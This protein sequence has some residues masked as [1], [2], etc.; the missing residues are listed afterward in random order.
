[1]E[2]NDELFRT[3]ANLPPSELAAFMAVAE[4]GGFRSAARAS[5]ASASA[6]SHAVAG[7]EAR[8]KAQLF[9][10]TTRRVALTEAGERFA[11]ALRPALKQ[12]SRA[13][14]A[15]DG[16]SDQPRGTIRINASARAAEL[17]LEPL[18]L[19]FLR[20]YPDMT[21]DIR[22]DD[23]LL[24]LGSGAFD[25]GLRLI[26]MV[27][28][29]MVAIPVGGEQQ[30]VVVAAPSYL[31]DVSA[32]STP[33]D[34]KAHDCIQWR[35]AGAARYRW[36]FE[37]HGE[38]LT[39]ETQGRLILD[40][41]RLITIAVRAGAGIGY[42]AKAAIEEDLADGTLVQLLHEWTPPYPGLALYY[43]KNRHMSAGMRA[44]IAF[45]RKLNRRDGGPE[46]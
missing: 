4:H 44:L 42:V 3:V 38:R 7:L 18:I 21:V 27:P 32:P 12:L 43:P 20:R 29:D 13:V 35:L 22:S 46:H 8:L 34:L 40:D 45:V 41:A 16:L 36:E 14:E 24:D 33:A 6:L 28:E 26:E 5:G 19:E 15:L 11:E 1:M 31:R 30:H 37:L 25:C 39:I 10:R 2:R 9:I 17:V 23:N